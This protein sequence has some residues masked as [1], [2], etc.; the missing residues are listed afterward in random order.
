MFIFSDHEPSFEDAFFEAILGPGSALANFLEGF[1]SLSFN[2]FIFGNYILFLIFLIMAFKLLS[3][4]K[5]KEYH[6]KVFGRNLEY[7]KKHGRVGTSVCIFI[8]IGFLFKILTI[9]FFYMSET[10]PAPF[11]FNWLGLN[12]VYY[13]S[14]SLNTLNTLNL[15]EKSLVFLTG[16]VS[17]ISVLLIC[18]GLYL[19]FFNKRILRTRYKSGS[20]FFSGIVLG[21]I[22]GFGPCFR[23]LL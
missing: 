19:M 6:E 20:V 8:S 12:H 13:N 21:V 7:V 5:Y 2:I 9:L 16:L 15:L 10:L 17:L 18:I 4:A 3:A 14:T 22:F 1:C 11:I 23:M